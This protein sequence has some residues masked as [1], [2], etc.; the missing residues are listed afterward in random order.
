MKIYYKYF[1]VFLF[2]G[3]ISCQKEKDEPTIK[4]EYE[5]NFEQFWNNFDQTYSYFSLKQV[6][7]DAVYDESKSKIKPQTTSTEFESLLAD[8]IFSLKDIHVRLITDTKTHRYSNSDL[9]DRNS[10]AN[11]N[12]YMTSVRVN[13]PT[14]TIGDIENTN[15][16]YLRVKNLIPTGD[17]D[18]LNSVLEDLPS[19]DGLILDLRDN[20]GG[21]D[22]IAKKFVNRLTHKNVVHGYVRVRNG[23]GRDDFGEW[24]ERRLTPDNPITFNKPITVLT[25]RFVVSSGEGFVSMMMV[26]PNTTLIGDTTR[27][28]TAN[29]KEFSLPN[30][31]KYRVS[32]WQATTA[33]HQLIE[34]RGIAPDIAI[35][36]TEKSMEEGKDLILEKAIEVIQNSN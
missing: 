7:W 8:I 34:D 29:P 33:M 22:G 2:I 6:D 16:A 23:A 12:R 26:L 31:W 17:F 24:Y 27:G 21:N 30:G 15:I 10:P 35:T 5:S 20:N 18:P 4:S 13:T 25:N 28:A 32:S 9:F 14:L 3:I 36:N 1:I 11:A 19:K